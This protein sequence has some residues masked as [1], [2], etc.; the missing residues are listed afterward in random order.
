MKCMFVRPRF[1]F[2]YASYGQFLILRE[3]FYHC[4]FPSCT[5]IAT[6]TI[7]KQIVDQSKK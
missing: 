3:M 6:A 2:K 1:H 7:E 4:E 5:N